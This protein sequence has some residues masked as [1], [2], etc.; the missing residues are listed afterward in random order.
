MA[1]IMDIRLTLSFKIFSVKPVY[2]IKSWH[3]KIIA[4]E[5][6]KKKIVQKHIKTNKKQG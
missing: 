4:P 6:K 5:K 2:R 3:C 1:W